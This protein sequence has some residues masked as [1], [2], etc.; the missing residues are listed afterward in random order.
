MLLFLKINDF[1]LFKD[2]EIAFDGDFTVITGETGAGKSMFIKALRFVL[3]EKQDLPLLNFSV[4]A[5]FKIKKFN[6]TL[7]QILQENDIELDEGSLIFRRTLTADN[8]NKIFVNDIPVTLKFLRIVSEELVEFHSQHKQLSSFNQSNSLNLIDQFIQDNSILLKISSLS[9]QIN[10][11]N[12]EI[13]DL[14]FK[15]KQIEGEREYITDS[16]KEIKQ[17]NLKEGEEL[18]LIEKK[19]LFADKSKVIE[20]L[21]NMIDVISGDFNIS[22][23]LIKAQRALSKFQHEL[24]LE[25]N[26]EN[27]IFHI[28]ELHSKIENKL[29]KLDQE[30]DIELIEERISKIKELCRKY[31]CTSDQ[32]INIGNDLVAKINLL[33]NID[34]SIKQKK[35]EKER[36]I[37]EYFKDS[38]FLSEARK[39][40]ARTLEDKIMHELKMLKLEQVE[41]KIDIVSFPENIT[42]KG[43]DSSRFLI[44]TNKGFEFTEIDKT[45]SG[46][47]LS[48]IMLAFKV[49]LM[50]NS[51]KVTIIFDEIDTGTGGA[52]A[53][54]IGKRMKALSQNDQIIAISH[55][56]QVASKATQHLLV[57]K[58]NHLQART[59]IRE[60]DKEERVNEIARMLSGVNI[61]D[62]AIL[63]ALDLIEN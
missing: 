8:K 19:K 20:T 61:T 40:T 62:S 56:P 16:L 54:T 31:R 34:S 39:M 17:L 36:L 47:E 14:E 3:G 18:E 45:A 63:T 49:A 44:R 27:V 22:G 12:S 46:G 53:E 48:R 24:N 2:Q 28:N 4:T 11:I 51:Q 58:E 6:H 25:E 29:S 26:I 9:N 23:K 7:K 43:I 10:K 55:Q 52:V 50:Q 42:S 41:F 38:K 30:E 57:E 15:K 13:A 5:E 33:E 60:L 37:Q 1:L 32:L 21:R 59:I 35:L